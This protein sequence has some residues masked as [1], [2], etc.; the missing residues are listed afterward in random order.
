MFFYVFFYSKLLIN[1][2]CALLGLTDV[3]PDFR[4]VSYT[5]NVNTN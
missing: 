4:P 3:V 2:Q 1:V 5:D